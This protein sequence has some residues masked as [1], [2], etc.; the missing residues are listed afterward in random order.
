MNTP[1]A[2]LVV[3]DERIVAKDLPQTLKSLGDD[4]FAI[5]S[6]AEEAIRLAAERCPDV[7]LVDIRIKRDTDG[8]ESAAILR[9]RFGVAVIYLTAHADAATLDRAKRAQPTVTS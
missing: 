3:E 8:V 5:A 7:A 1:P 6:S 9:R 4:A 2:I